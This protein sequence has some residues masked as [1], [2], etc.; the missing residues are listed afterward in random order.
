MKFMETLQRTDGSRLLT[1]VSAARLV[2]PGLQESGDDEDGFLVVE[3]VRDL[4]KPRSIP[5]SRN[6]RLGELAA[7]AAHEIHNP[8]ASV[9]I[10]LQASDRILETSE[11]DVSELRVSATGA[12]TD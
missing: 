3:A 7:G 9:S 5:M 6:S 10:A 11:Q 4:E 8:L 1:E 12:G 2:V